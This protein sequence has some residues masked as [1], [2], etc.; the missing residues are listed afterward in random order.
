MLPTTPNTAALNWIPV[1][2]TMELCC[3]VW[4][5]AAL[6]P[7]VLR[8][9][10]YFWLGLVGNGGAEGSG[11]MAGGSRGQ[12]MK[13]RGWRAEGQIKGYGQHPLGVVSGFN[14]GPGAGLSQWALLDSVLNQYPCR[15]GGGGGFWGP[16]REGHTECHKHQRLQAPALS[17]VCTM[18]CLLS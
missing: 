12:K 11:E 7:V 17:T 13:D 6:Q 10:C 1:L 3:P 18:G 4:P 9:L 14:L 2:C 8:R 16:Y 5:S 15:G